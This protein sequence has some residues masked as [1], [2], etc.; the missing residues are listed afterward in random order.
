MNTCQLYLASSSPRR[1]RLLDQIG[2]RYRI[3]KP[4]ILEE[5][6][7][8]ELPEEMVMRLAIEKARQGEEMAVETRPVLG[9]DTIVL[10]RNIILGKP[11]NRQEA[12]EMLSRLSGKTHRVLTA[13]AVCQEDRV[14]KA[15]SETL[16]GFRHLTEEEQ[17]N[18][19]NTDEPM[20]KAGAYAIQGLGAVFVESIKGSY[21]GVV[22]LPLMETSRLLSL[23]GIKCLGNSNNGLV[24]DN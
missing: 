12:K 19:C 20:D 14:E 22:G 4:E 15:I 2:V 5:I 21:S 1:A 7:G 11:S 18:Y 8:N 6:A 10:D 13:V 24:R 23:F 3:V 9:A 16:V 17:I